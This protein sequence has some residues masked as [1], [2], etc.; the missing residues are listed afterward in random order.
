MKKLA[1]VKTIL[2]VEDEMPLQKA[3]RI[4]LEKN[5][6]SV[7]TARNVKQAINH[8]KDIEGIEAIWLDHYLLGKETGLDVVVK[9]K[10]DKNWKKIPLFII[11]NTASPRKVQNYIKLGINKYYTKSDH[12]LDQIIS[13]ITKGLKPKRK[14][15]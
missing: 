12:R 14:C 5:N 8:L 7:V 10:D 2:V 6:F 13:D 3:I 4:K 9:L 15:K 1:Q 11:S